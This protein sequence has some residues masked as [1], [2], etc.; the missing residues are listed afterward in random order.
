MSPRSS[1]RPSDHR[2]RLVRHHLPLAVAS[3]AVLALFMTLPAFD[4]Q[5]YPRADMAGPLPKP[6]EADRSAQES[7]A[8]P[9]HGGGQAPPA[10]HAAGQSPQPGHGSG[11]TPAPGHGA[12]TTPPASHAP[13]QAPGAGHGG[14][15]L[16]AIQERLSAARLTVA[17]G[18]VATGLLAVTLTIGPANLLLRQRNP[19]SSWSRG[20]TTT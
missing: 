17:T 8:S 6:L 4:P 19:V 7:A 2:R 9:G 15:P 5:A 20:A 16:A 10:G 11:S 3:G 12:G 13:A 18:Y 14:P 1:D